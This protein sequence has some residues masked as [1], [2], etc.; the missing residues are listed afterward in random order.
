MTVQPDGALSTFLLIEHLL[1]V[2]NSVLPVQELEWDSL[3]IS[4]WKVLGVLLLPFTQFTSLISGED[5]TTLSSVF[6]PMIVDIKIHLEEV[7]DFNI[8]RDLQVG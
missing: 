4:K 3:A 5:F 2:K 7:L 8:D 1:E 6:S